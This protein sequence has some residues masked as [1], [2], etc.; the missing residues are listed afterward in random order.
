MLQKGFV[1]PCLYFRSQELTDLRKSSMP[2]LERPL[3]GTVQI[4]NRTSV[5]FKLALQKTPDILKSEPHKTPNDAKTRVNQGVMAASSTTQ[6][7]RIQ[8]KEASLVR[9]RMCRERTTYAGI[10]LTL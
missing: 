9:P 1:S 7:G 10:I 6:T 5:L 3:P 4:H 2:P 8:L